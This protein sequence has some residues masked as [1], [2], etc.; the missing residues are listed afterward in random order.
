MLSNQIVWVVL[1][2]WKSYENI[3][4][5]RAFLKNYSNSRIAL[6]YSSVRRWVPVHKEIKN[7]LHVCL[8]DKTQN[9]CYQVTRMLAKLSPNLES[10]DTSKILRLVTIDEI[11]LGLKEWADWGVKQGNFTYRVLGSLLR[12]CPKIAPRDLVSFAI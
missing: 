11:A 12:R 9:I 8:F 4:F 2:N 7:I 1:L 10:S 3:N 5:V 6:Y